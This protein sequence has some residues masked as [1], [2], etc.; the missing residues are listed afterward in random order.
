MAPPKK[1]VRP[2]QQ[3]ALDG[4]CGIYSLFN[5][6]RIVEP[7]LTE[8][9][10]H[11]LFATCLTALEERKDV[12]AINITGLTLRDLLFLNR[13][14]FKPAFGIRHVRPFVKAKPRSLGHMW[15]TFSE[16]L[17]EPK[18]AIVLSF[19]SEDWA[20]WTVVQDIDEKAL[21]LADSDGMRTILRKEVS[22]VKVSARRPLCIQ[23]RDVFVVRRSS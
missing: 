15:R 23:W 7:N 10:C 4:F 22:I 20:H 17:A 6:A 5:A 14:V 13:Q 1:R 21:W 9:A 19:S 2:L 12:P 18:T 11:A 3:G 16:V 8:N